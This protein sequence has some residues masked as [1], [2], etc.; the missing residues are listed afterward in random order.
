MENRGA[1]AV[2][3][4]TP[5]S[6]KVPREPPFR[7]SSARRPSP[8]TATFLGSLAFKLVRIKV[9]QSVDGSQWQWQCK[10]RTHPLSHSDDQEG[11]MI[12]HTRVRKTMTTMIMMLVTTIYDHENHGDR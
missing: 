1:L 2:E 8:T 4:G 6:R 7:C 12:R 11:S 3:G 9:P 10:S 5:L